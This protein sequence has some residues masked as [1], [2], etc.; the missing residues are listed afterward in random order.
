M[1][2][3]Q[4]VSAEQ[5]DETSRNLHWD[6]VGGHHQRAGWT[7]SVGEGARSKYAP[8]AKGPIP[9]TIPTV[10]SPPPPPPSA[11]AGASLMVYG[12]QVKCVSSGPSAG[13]ASAR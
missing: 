3:I 4:H 6:D 7:I 1:S 8:V 2:S 12:C 11:A 9:P 10:K 13:V 5:R